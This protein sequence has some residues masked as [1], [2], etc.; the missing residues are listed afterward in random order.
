MSS[1]AFEI[2]V[3]QIDHASRLCSTCNTT[4]IDNDDDNDGRATSSASEAQIESVLNAPQFYFSAHD[5]HQEFD[6]SG[7]QVS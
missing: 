4:T 2:K 1:H 3:E 6:D 5:V 7:F